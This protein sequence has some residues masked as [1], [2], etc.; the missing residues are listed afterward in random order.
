[1]AG[2]DREIRLL[3]QKMDLLLDGYQLL[4]V[5]IEQQTRLLN[6]L[7]G[8]RTLLSDANDRN[9][10]RMSERFLERVRRK[11]TDPDDQGIA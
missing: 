9:V 1:M 7:A 10:L 8:E 6:K 4:F 2:F 3:K 11:P 5:K